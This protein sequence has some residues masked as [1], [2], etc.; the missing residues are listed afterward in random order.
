MGPY[1]ESEKGNKFVLVIVNSF[2]KWME[3][4]PVP[5]NKGKVQSREVCHGIYLPLWLSVQIKSDRRKQFNFELF[6]Y[7][8]QLLDME[9]KMS[10]PF[11]LQGNSRVERMVKVVRNLIVSFARLTES[12][13]R[14]CLY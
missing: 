8:C 13:K 11:H 10:T 5:N 12:G 2:S 14:T 6:Q 3:A 9:R 4:Y 7:M 1:K